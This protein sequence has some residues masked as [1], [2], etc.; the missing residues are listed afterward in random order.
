[1]A[2]LVFTSGLAAGLSHRISFKSDAFKVM[3]CDASYKPDRAQTK[4]GDVIGEIVA[5]GYVEGG[6][7]VD[8][9][10]GQD[11]EKIDI[12]LGGAQWP[13]ASIKA[14][15]AVYYRSPGDDLIAVID[16]GDDVISSNGPFTV[17]PSILRIRT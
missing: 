11:G 15:Y 5:P 3:L 9:S 4:R 10:L 6:A 2:S 7:P 13:D 12:G 17:S 8:L 16:F 14:R 1:M